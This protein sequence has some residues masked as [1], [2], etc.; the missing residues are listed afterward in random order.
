MIAVLDG[1]TEIGI[2]AVAVWLVSR[3]QMT[4]QKKVRVCVAFA[5]RLG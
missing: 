1:A 3:L 2:L 5:C 4:L